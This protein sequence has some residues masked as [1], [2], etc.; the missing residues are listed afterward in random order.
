MIFPI[1]IQVAQADG[2]YHVCFD[3]TGEVFGNFDT[4]Q[5]AKVA[6]DEARKVAPLGMDS[7]KLSG[8]LIEKFGVTQ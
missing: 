4:W 7:T 8:L 5:A 1:D 2:E 3:P 6:R